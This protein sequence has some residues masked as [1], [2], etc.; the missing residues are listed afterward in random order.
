MNIYSKMLVINFVVLN[1][2]VFLFHSF[3]VGNAIIIGLAAIFLVTL[4]VTAAIVRTLINDSPERQKLILIL[5][6]PGFGVLMIINFLV[7]SGSAQV[8]SSIFQ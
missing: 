6:L 5:S 7:A 2:L 1:L 4:G 3:F 8:C